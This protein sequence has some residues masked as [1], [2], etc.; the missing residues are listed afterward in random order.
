[1]ALAEKNFGSPAWW[2]WYPWIRVV[3]CVGA[4]VL[5]WWPAVV[6]LQISVQ[7]R[8]LPGADIAIGYGLPYMMLS[9]GAGIYLAMIR[10][11]D[12]RSLLSDR[13]VFGIAAVPLPLFFFRVPKLLAQCF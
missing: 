10:F 13:I 1:M 2:L 5:A 11:G 6:D 8:F 7:A 4:L 9:W 3:T 12:P